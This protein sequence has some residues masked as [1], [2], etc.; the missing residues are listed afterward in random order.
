MRGNRVLQAIYFAPLSSQPKE[1]NAMP[2]ETYAAEARGSTHPDDIG[3]TTSQFASFRA[4]SV[5]DREAIGA[6][7]EAKYRMKLAQDQMREDV[8]AIAERLGM[9][10]S[11]LN[12]IVRLAMRERERGNVLQHEKAL[13][14]LAEQI[15]I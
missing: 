14:E 10:S 12:R 15:F 8:K 6:M 3:A 5:H 7:I 11:E 1:L 2:A 13:I 9:K 4:L